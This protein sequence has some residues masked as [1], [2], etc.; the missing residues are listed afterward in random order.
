MIKKI[1]G[2]ILLSII[3]VLICLSV[4]IYGIAMGRPWYE[5]IIVVG[6]CG[7]IVGLMMLGIYLIA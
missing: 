7:I 4:I 5:G 6:I 3:S 2:W 1:I